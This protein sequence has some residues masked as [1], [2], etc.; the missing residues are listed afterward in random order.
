MKKVKE[1]KIIEKQMRDKYSNYLNKHKA[2]NNN[3]VYSPNKNSY[4]NTLNIEKN[5]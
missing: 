5:S 2:T 4:K 1:L 3:S